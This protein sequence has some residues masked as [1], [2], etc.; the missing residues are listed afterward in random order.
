MRRALRGLGAGA[1][2][3]VVRLVR[4]IPAAVSKFFQDRGSQLAAAIS[5]RVLFS[6]V[7]LLIFSVSIAGLVL[8]DDERRQDLVAQLVDRFGLS[9]DSG[10]DLEQT[11]SSVPT[12]ASVAGI[13]S[14][15]GFLWA[16]TGM[17]GAIRVGLTAAFD[18]GSTRPILRSKA[19]DVLLV[20][21]V[22]G[23]LL[24]SFG[25]S[26]AIHAAARWSEPLA[27]ALS[28]AGFGAGGAAGIVVPLLATF[29]A[30]TLLYHFVP[31]SRPPLRDVW[32][33]AALAAI[34]FEVVQ[35]GFSYYLATVATY[36]V[37]YGSLGSL[38]GFLFVVYISA[39][40]FLIGAELAF[41]WPRS[42]EPGPPSEPVPFVRRVK[43]AVRGL[44]V[45]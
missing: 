19:V 22:G 5:Y 33:A 42:A 28:S 15:L 35:V 24:I 43:G 34:A 6:I 4:A 30:I 21:A 17:M 18:D 26:V 41:Q 27:D 2:R 13:V 10:V 3:A 16:A 31:P 25:L 12:P 23:L 36:N 14:I 39:S 44:F 40:V 32:V 8:Q 9:A 7:P 37:L 20:L 45:K 1:K 38:F 29:G 11:L